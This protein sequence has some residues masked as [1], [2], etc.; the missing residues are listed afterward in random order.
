MDEREEGEIRNEQNCQRCGRVPCTCRRR[1]ISFDTII[2]SCSKWNGRKEKYDEWTDELKSYLSLSPLKDLIEQA[3]EAE[4]EEWRDELV[5]DIELNTI[6]YNILLVLTTE[7]ARTLINRGKATHQ[8]RKDHGM[9]AFYIPETT[10]IRKKGL[11]C[12]R[13][14]PTSRIQE[15]TSK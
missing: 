10:R 1:V 11:D 3:E 4:P 13:D 7:D 9:K 15:V 8:D 2:K 5:Q 6:L 14:D 12:S